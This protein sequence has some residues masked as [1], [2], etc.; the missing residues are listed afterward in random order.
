[1]MAAQI[2]GQRGL[3]TRKKGGAW[4]KA[5]A[6]MHGG[7][8]G[9]G[10]GLQRGRPGSRRGGAGDK[11]VPPLKIIFG[12]FLSDGNR[13]N[14][15]RLTATGEALRRAHKEAKAESRRWPRRKFR[16]TTPATKK[17]ND[18]QRQFAI[19]GGVDYRAVSSHR[20]RGAFLPVPIRVAGNE[21]VRR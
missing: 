21:A 20:S 16:G 15:S 5:D 4:K 8:G 10:W 19:R 7:R 13:E 14:G 1:M 2:Y 3:Q 17:K 18:Y 12:A 6:P 9:K 11:L